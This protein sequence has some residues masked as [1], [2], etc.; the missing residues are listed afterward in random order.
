MAFLIALL[1]AYIYEFEHKT[2]LSAEIMESPLWV[3][4]IFCKVYYLKKNNYFSFRMFPLTMISL[5]NGLSILGYVNI[6][7]A[8]AGELFPTEGKTAATR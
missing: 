3:E 5:F 7:T 6:P 8:M 2:F 4:M 1:A